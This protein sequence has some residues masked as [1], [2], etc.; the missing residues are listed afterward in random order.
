MWLLPH[1]AGRAIDLHEG[2]PT[3]FDATGAPAA[4]AIAPNGDVLIGT[5]DGIAY[6]DHG[7]WQIIG[8]AVGMPTATTRALLVDRE[9]T[10]WI[11]SAGLFR[12]RGRGLLEHHNVA[13]GLPGEIVWTYQRDR[14]GTL[15]AGTNRCL[16]RAVG[17][18]WECLPGT[19]SRVVRAIVFPPQGGMFIGGAPSDLLYIDPA[20]HT[21]SL[22]ETNRPE[23][24]IFG[25]ALGPEGDLWIATR[26]GLERLPGAV[27]GPTVP[28]SV[29]GVRGNS[30]FGS[31][32]V[33]EGRL[34]TT[35]APGGVA[36]LDG[37]VW[38]LFGASAGFRS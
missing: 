20:G 9:G 18:R 3:G 19:E 31:V 16:A 10:I 34:W 7:R 2:F 1:G 12:L 26:I 17:R 21:T 14:A 4:M 38:H 27:P 13:S 23:R 36:V 28:V 30:R 37:A 6:R 8:H 33:A 24:N 25:L 11:G 15:W 32:L 29:P 35:A 5:D 22:G